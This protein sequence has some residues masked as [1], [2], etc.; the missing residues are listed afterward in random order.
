[1]A[2]AM[3]SIHPF[4]GF[5][6]DGDQFDRAGSDEIDILPTVAASV[7]ELAR[8]EMNLSQRVK[9]NTDSL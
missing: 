2:G 8:I 6:I 5:G 7:G 1:M 4:A 9:I 3:A